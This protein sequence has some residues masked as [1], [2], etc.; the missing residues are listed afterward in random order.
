MFLGYLTDCDASK[1]LNSESGISNLKHK[2]NLCVL[3]NIYLSHSFHKIF[4]WSKRF[5]GTYMLDFKSTSGDLSRFHQILILRL[6]NCLILFTTSSE[7]YSR[8]VNLLDSFG[9]LDDS[10]F[11]TGASH[12]KI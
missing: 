4:L 8:Y 12:R 6:V 11:G 7:I 1:A 10:G 5:S 9:H 3:Q 2:K